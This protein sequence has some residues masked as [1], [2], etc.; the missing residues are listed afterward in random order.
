MELDLLNVRVELELG[1]DIKMVLGLGWDI[2]MLLE[3]REVKP[4]AP[5]ELPS[6]S[7]SCSSEIVSRGKPS[8]S[9]LDMFD[10]KLCGDPAGV[11]PFLVPLNQMSK[12][13]SLVV[14]SSLKR[15]LL[16]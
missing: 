14:G 5:G 11:D 6:V 9:W 15:N 13:L 1:L 12:P 2:K 3:R 10:L 16:D 4:A 7:S 8:R